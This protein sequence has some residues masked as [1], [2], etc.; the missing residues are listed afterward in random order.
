[1]EILE[2]A[3][4]CFSVSCMFKNVVDQFEWAFT[5][6]YGPNSDKD[7]RLLWEEL[8]GLC[9]WWNVT[10]TVG[11]IFFFFFLISKNVI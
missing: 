6:V 2:E 1:M 10:W 5:G 9:S 7:R 3:V 11:G 8:S 4:G